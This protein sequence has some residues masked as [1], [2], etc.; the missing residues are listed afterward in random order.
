L[1]EVSAKFWILLGEC[2]SKC[3]HISGTPLAPETADNFYRIYLAKGALGTAAIEGNTLSEKDVLDHLDGKLELPPSREYLKQEIDNIVD[4]CNAILSEVASGN[5]PPI[6]AQRVMNLNE[7]VLK[8][9]S[10]EKDIIPGQIRKDTHGVGRYRAAPP[11]DCEFLLGKLCDWLN[12]STFIGKE[13]MILAILKAILAHLYIAWIHPFGD[14]N[15]RTARLIEFQILISSGFP[16]P[17]AHLLSNYYNQTR[18]EY[19]KQLDSASASGGD[20]RPFLTYAITGFAEGLRLQIE[21][22]KKQQMKTVWKNY[23]HQQCGDLEH[24]RRERL[25]QLVLDL[26]EKAERV[27]LSDLKAIT[28]KV[29]IEYA[30]ITSDKTLLRDIKLLSGLNLVDWNGETIRAKT[31]TISAWLPI[32]AAIKEE[33]EQQ[34]SMSPSN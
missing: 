26:S 13:R 23:V 31:E 6:N 19:Y 20:I 4:A 25:V 28:P 9:L 22:L 5:L 1:T 24:F 32:K 27:S 16:A 2:Q 10:L 14:G 15:G 17:A 33:N 3:E 18:N 30:K 11:E 12:G 7:L 29:A 21:E 34:P 8:N